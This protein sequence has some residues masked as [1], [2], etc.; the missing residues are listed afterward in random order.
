MP[1][2]CGLSIKQIRDLHLSEDL[3][4][5]PVRIRV[6]EVA[7]PAAVPSEPQANKAMA[8]ALVM[9]ALCGGGLAVVRNWLDQTLRSADEISENFGLSV[10]A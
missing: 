7:R 6:M 4:L 2:I 3:E 5:E 9:G 8:V 10:L 1:P